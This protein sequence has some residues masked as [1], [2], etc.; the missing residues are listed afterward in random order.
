LL[1][2]LMA[3]EGRPVSP[4]EL[5]AHV[6]GYL[7][8]A[9]EARSLVRVHISRLRAKVERDSTNPK[10]ILTIRGVGYAFGDID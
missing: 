9:D 4:E 1:A 8:D 5:V 7:T 3:A 6:H 2:H 10:T